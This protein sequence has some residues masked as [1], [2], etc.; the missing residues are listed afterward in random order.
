MRLVQAL[1][2]TANS[3]PMFSCEGEESATVCEAV[4]RDAP[5]CGPPPALKMSWGRSPGEETVEEAGQAPDGVATIDAGQG[6][7]ATT[8][9]AAKTSGRR[10]SVWLEQHRTR[11]ER[12]KD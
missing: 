7:D 6:S 3:T 4:S 10:A 9:L 11:G 2:I 8:I 1:Y 5:S 12:P